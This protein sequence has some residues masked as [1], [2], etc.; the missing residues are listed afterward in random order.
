MVRLQWYLEVQKLAGAAICRFTCAQR[1]RSAAACSTTCRQNRSPQSKDLCTVGLDRGVKRAKFNNYILASSAIYD[2]YPPPPPPP[3]PPQRIEKCVWGREVC[4][5]P[6]MI[7]LPG[8]LSMN[9]MAIVNSWH[10]VARVI[11]PM[12]HSQDNFSRNERS[13]LS[14][15]CNCL[16]VASVYSLNLRKLP[17]CFSY[18]AWEWGWGK[19]ELEETI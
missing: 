7:A 2:L 9:I 11:S 14:E 8:W 13:I 3:P 6:L 19:R 16:D 5:G 1:M 4:I 17:G 12:K 18:M 10:W 15:V